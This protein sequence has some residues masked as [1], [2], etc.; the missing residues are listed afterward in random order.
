MGGLGFRLLIG[1]SRARRISSGGSAGFGR[2]LMT[3]CALP[4]G[5][6]R[7]SCG[8]GIKACLFIVG[9][10]SLFLIGPSLIMNG[11]FLGRSISHCEL[12]FK[13]RNR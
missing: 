1:R 7:C 4:S 8:I 6:L 11:I 9:L 5:S 10:K 12:A 13:K 2:L 3:F